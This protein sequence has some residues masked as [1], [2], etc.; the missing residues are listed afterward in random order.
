[1]SYLMPPRVPTTVELPPRQAL[2]A[3]STQVL[4]VGG[5]R[6]ASARPSG[7]PTRA[8]RWSSWSA[9]ASSAATPPRPW[10]C[11]S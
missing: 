6:P 7:R 5:V 11:R 9:T 1:M 2:H 3:G 4:V 8:P 10:S